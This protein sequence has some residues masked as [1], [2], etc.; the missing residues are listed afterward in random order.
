[1]IAEPEFEARRLAAVRRT[2][3]LD[4]P[5]EPEFD[6]LVATAAAVCG[7][8]VSVV[9]LIDESRQFFKAAVG[10][11]HRETPREVAFCDVAIRHDEMLLVE[12]A[13]ADE[14]FCDNPLVTVENGIRFYAGV[15]LR[16]HDGYPLGTLCVFDSHPRTL[17]EAQASALRSLAQQVNARIELRVQ[18]LQLEQTLEELKRAN[19]K[20]EQLAATDGLTGLANRRTLDERLAWEMAQ[21]RRNAR[22]LGLL[23]LDIDN[24]KQRNDTFGHED[25]DQV[26][27]QFGAILKRTARESDLAA[28][29]GGEEFAIL[30]PETEEAM[31]MH[32]AHRVLDAVHAEVWMHRP[33][34]VSVGAAAITIP[35]QRGEDLLRL[36]DHALYAAKHAGKDRA[37]GASRSA[38]VEAGVE[39]AAI[40][41]HTSA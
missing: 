25:G 3:L 35:G 15:P 2:G 38:A 23:M 17:N 21:R 32:L 14:R 36:A 30:L 19:L 39:A 26:L 11:E 37:V 27:R 34:T 12:D 40:A 24:F 10:L 41:S 4:T 29:Y 5:P 31:A 16:S 18:R 1:M 28:R 33:V 6:E 20:L 9:S 13:T 22:P 7:T 8:A